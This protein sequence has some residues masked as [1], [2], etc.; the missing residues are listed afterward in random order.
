MQAVPGNEFYELLS[1][2]QADI[3]TFLRNPIKDT[4][5]VVGSLENRVKTDFRTFE[6]KYPQE[7]SVALKAAETAALDLLPR[8]VAAAQEKQSRQRMFGHWKYV[9]LSACIISFSVSMLGP[10]VPIKVMGGVG[11][12]FFGAAVPIIMARLMGSVSAYRHDFKE[13]VT[14]SYVEKQYTPLDLQ[15]FSFA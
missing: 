6:E 4:L 11:F 5:S 12:L 15:G 10:T 2:T 8:Y 13:A 3:E 1:N 9:S 7:D 14:K